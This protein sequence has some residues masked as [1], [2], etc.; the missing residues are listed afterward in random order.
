VPAGGDQD[1]RC[2]QAHAVIALDRLRRDEARTL[3]QQGNARLVQ[4]PPVAVVDPLDVALALR[5]QHFPVGHRRRNREAEVAGQAD[6]DGQFRGQP[7]RLLRHAAGIDAGAAQRRRFQQRDP[8]AVLRGAES[9]GKPGRAAAQ[10]D[11]VEVAGHNQ[12]LNESGNRLR[13][14]IR[15]RKADSSL[16]SE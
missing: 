7:H 13:R 10:H 12:S 15:A 1:P 5:H 3:R 4:P 2:G 14:C 6:P 9:A 8:R 16:R 11:Q